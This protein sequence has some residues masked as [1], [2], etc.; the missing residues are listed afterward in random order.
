MVTE[1][2]TEGLQPTNASGLRTVHIIIIAASVCVPLLMCIL[3]SAILICFYKWKRNKNSSDVIVSTEEISQEEKNYSVEDIPLT[4]MRMDSSKNT[5][6]RDGPGSMK[7][8]TTTSVKKGSSKGGRTNNN[9]GLKETKHKNISSGVTKSTT[10]VTKST[11]AVFNNA[12]LVENT[13][14]NKNPKKSRSASKNSTQHLNYDANSVPPHPTTKDPSAAKKRAG[15]HQ[16]VSGSSSINRAPP[17]RSAPRA[18]A[19]G[20]PSA[21]H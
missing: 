17:S 3:L 21:A 20:H 15:G 12:C 14:A 13:T 2:V 11:T 16:P 4:S 9:D 10:A 7:K 8:D 5:Q 6:E 18:P 1:M 19:C